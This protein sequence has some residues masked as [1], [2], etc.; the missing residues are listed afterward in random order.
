MRSNNGRAR[1]SGP[2]HSVRADIAALK[3]D[4]GGLLAEGVGA[5]GEGTTRALSAARQGAGRLHG[6]LAD[7]T[8][9]RPLTTIAVSAVAGA[10]VF[11]AIGWLIRR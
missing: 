9:N 10:V 6:R 11:R 8:S 1:A 2:L 7:L 4:L 3:R 5:A